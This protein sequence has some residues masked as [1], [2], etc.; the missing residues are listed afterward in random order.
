MSLAV[1]THEL[2]LQKVCPYIHIPSN[3]ISDKELQLNKTLKTGALLG[4][5]TALH[6][7]TEMVNIV[8]F[9]APHT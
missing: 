9:Q 2:Y 4:F 5:S 7:Q 3:I 8:V 1:Q 6:P